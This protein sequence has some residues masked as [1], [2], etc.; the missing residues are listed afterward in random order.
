MAKIRKDTKG[1]VLHKGE[2]YKKEKKLYRY[3]YTDP[4]GKRRCI[5]SK[6][7]GE[8]REKEKQLQRDQLD[9]LDMYVQGKADVNF[10]FDRYI[11]TKTELRSSTRT[12]YLYTY[13][14]YVRNGFG[15]KKLSSVR[16]S[17]VVL[18]YNAL[19][20]KGLSVS[21]VDSVHTVLRPTFQ[22]AVRDNVIR[23]NP[24]D[25]AMAEVNKKWDGETGVR[26]ALTIEEERAFL[27]CLNLQKNLKW[28][29]LFTVMFGTGCRIGEVIGLRWDDADMDNGIITIDHDITYYPR[30]DKNYKCEYELALPKTEAGIRTI[31]MLKKVKEALELEKENQEKYGYHCVVE[32]G[33]MKN[34]IF[35][36]RFGGLLNPAGVNKVIK[37]IVSDHNAKE[38]V[39]AKKE[40][41]VP[42]IIPDF[43]CHITRHTFCT[44]LCENETN[45]KVIQS[46]M[47]HKDIQTT[48]DIYAEVSEKKKKD[49]FDQ[50]NDHDVI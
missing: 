25:G 23:N 7:L 37:R 4:L 35:C 31:P 34:F 33:G 17:D 11:A 45:V 40:G 43:S 49:I 15:K 26:H 47:G 46:V 22:L 38:I 19:L 10:A 36:N 20:G 9:G 14:R 39:D 32:L 2:D 50:L 48:L 5:Y 12:N 8:L 29:P 13:D 27:D 30:S 24:A 21:T 18:F 41:R 42:V 6:D 1:K 44:R 16:Y 3:S 28:K